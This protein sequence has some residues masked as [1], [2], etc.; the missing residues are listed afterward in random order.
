MYQWA[1]IKGIHVISTGDFTHPAWFRELQDKLESDGNGLFRMKHTPTGALAGLPV[2]P[3]QPWL[4]S[5]KLKEI[6]IRFMLSAEI[7]SVYHYGGKIHKN[8]NLVYAPDFSS[9]A[10]INKQLSKYGDLSADGRLTISLSS[11]DLLEIILE[12]PGGKAFL[13]PAHAWDPWF[14]TLGSYDGYDSVD[15]CFRD[16][17][18]CIFAIE[19]GL[20]SDPAMNW[21]WSRLDRLTMLSGSDAHSPQKLG[22]EASLFSTARSYEAIFEAIKTQAG[23]LG[24]YES[25]PEEGQYYRDGHRDCGVCLSPE[26]SVAIGDRCPKCGRTLTI[27]VMQRIGKL[28]DRQTP[29]KPE[30][31]AS[32]RYIIPLSEILAEMLETGVDAK[33]VMKAYAAAITGFGNESDLLQL[34]PIEDLHRYD[35]LLAEAIRRMRNNEVIRQ[36]GYDG[37]YGKISL[38]RGKPSLQ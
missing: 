25:F 12:T 9:V 6:D 23:F 37:V 1:L 17:S 28:A 5:T 32:F 7:S 15:E 30:G 24:T 31:A 14:S 22:R 18:S 35:P 16:L 27:G 11:R 3:E 20:A 26:E 38:F 19:T 29:A 21:R 33:Q 4:D 36:P 8:H 10:W 34:A 2:D 13:V